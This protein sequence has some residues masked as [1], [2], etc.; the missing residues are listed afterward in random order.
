LVDIGTQ[1]DLIVV[2]R[3]NLNFLDSSEGILEFSRIPHCF[4]Y[5]PDH[6]PLKSPK[7]PVVIQGVRVPIIIDT[8]AEISILSSEFVANLFP[9]DDLSTNARDVRNLG[10][11]L[12][13][14]FGPI[15][16]TVVVC[17]LTL[18]HP[19]FYYENNPT[20]L[21]GID[22][23]ARAALTIDC[24]SRCVWSKHT[25]RCDVRQDLADATTKPTLHVNADK[26]LDMVPSLP[27]SFPDIETRESTD[28]H[29]DETALTQFSMAL[30][31]SVSESECE[32]SLTS[33][34]V[35]DGTQTESTSVRSSPVTAIDVGVQC[36]E[37]SV[38]TTLD[39]PVMSTECSFCS[40]MLSSSEILCPVQSTLNPRA[41]SF[42]TTS[43][44]SPASFARSRDHNLCSSA[45]ACPEDGEFNPP[46]SS[47]V[48]HPMS[49]FSP[50]ED[51]DEDVTL[52]KSH[53][54][55]GGSELPVQVREQ[56][57]E[58][59]VLTLTVEG[60]PEHVAQLFLDTY[61]Q[62][63]FPIEATH[64]L[65]QLLFDH[66][67]TFATS[68]ADIGFCSILQHDIDTGDA[69]PIRQ[70]PRKP[71]LAA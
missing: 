3:L 8:G 29:V 5:R 45:V 40:D 36:D 71:Q 44:R 28:G 61:Q 19:F 9:D 60:L 14:V 17:G 22:L 48:E 50:I 6:Q 1:T 4:Q 57:G 12:V 25:L 53:F 64:S 46:E 49:L 54:D 67:H 62:D 7:I 65:K 11:G 59:S 2:D 34:L 70:A 37:S 13:S 23:L 31:P 42:V 69:H 32:C 55:P 43:E 56:D 63:D 38:M 35:L 39:D 68:S 21:M 15:E 41:P 66:Q 16:L 30:N 24:E 51:H 47:L 18:E 52:L 27:L 26:F 10:G 20:F 58:R 33:D